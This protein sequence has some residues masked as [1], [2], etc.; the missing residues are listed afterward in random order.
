MD[1]FQD[2][3]YFF[4]KFAGEPWQDRLLFGL[5]KVFQKPGTYNLY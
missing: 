2:N 5:I 4:M 3:G 1:K